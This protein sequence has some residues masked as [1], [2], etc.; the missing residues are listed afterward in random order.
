[1]ET[2]ARNLAIGVVLSQ[3]GRL[4]AFFSKKLN[5]PKKYSMNDL[6]LYVMVQNLKK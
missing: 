6:E 5:D 4:V 1:M 2:D 3:V